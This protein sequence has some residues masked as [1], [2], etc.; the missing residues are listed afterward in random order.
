V[1][2][3]YAGDDCRIPED[4]RCVRKVVEQPHSCAEQH[5]SQIDVDLVE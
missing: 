3:T 5:G 4:G 2:D 1:R